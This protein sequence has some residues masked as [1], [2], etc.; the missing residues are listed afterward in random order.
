M[1]IEKT[2]I[3]HE[4][5]QFFFCHTPLHLGHYKA[6]VFSEEFSA[7]LW[8]IAL[9][10]LENE[11]ALTRWHRSVTILLEKSAG[12]PFIHKYR[13]IHLIESDLNFIMRK[14]R[15]R[16]FMRHNETAETFQN[17]QYGGRKG[18][19]STSAILNKVLT[20]DIIRYF[21]DDMA[22]IDNDAKACYD[23]VI[24]YVTLYMVRRLGMPIHLSRFLCNVLNSM[25][26]T[27]KTGTGLTTLYSANDNRLFGTGQCAGWL[28]PCWSANSDVI[29][30]VMEK[31]TPVMLLEHPSRNIILHRHIN[32]FVDDSSRLGITKTAFYKF[33]PATTAPVPKGTSLYH[34]AQLNTQFYSRLL[35]TTGGLLAIHKCIAYILLFEWVNG[36]RRMKKVKQILDP[37]KIQQG[38]NQDHDFITIKDPDEAFR[39]LG[40]FVAPDGNTKVKVEILYKKEKEWGLQI[41]FSH[42]NAQE[43]W[44]AYHQVLLPSLIYPLGAIPVSEADCQ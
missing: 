24:P 35:F 18:R 19:L 34:Q 11:Y 4:V 17:N 1:P 42:L 16:D 10:A 44:V 13:T 2:T 8:N 5:F 32:V 27:I 26:Y 30:T 9:I 40:G 25:T 22:I 33:N 38:I 20:L 43:A 28:P 36:T 41:T 29:S 6:A 15:G 12:N 31:H 3:S 37:I 23:R 14:V 21:G 7:I 39:M